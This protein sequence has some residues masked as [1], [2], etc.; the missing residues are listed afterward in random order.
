MEQILQSKQHVAVGC[1]KLCKASEDRTYCVG[2]GRTIEEI[3]AC[4]RNAKETNEDIKGSSR[5]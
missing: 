3:I 2:C 1:V 4:G 5:G